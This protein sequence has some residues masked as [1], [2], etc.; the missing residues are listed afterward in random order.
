MNE[1]PE[2]RRLTP[3]ELMERI[4][5]LRRIGGGATREQILEAIRKGRE[6]RTRQQLE[7]Y[8]SEDELDDLIAGDFSDVD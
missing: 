2:S 7:R 1:E 8:F 5:E 6:E 3:D 4:L